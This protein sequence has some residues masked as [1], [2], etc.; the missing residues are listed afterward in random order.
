MQF[1]QIRLKDKDFKVMEVQQ[2]NLTEQYAKFDSKWDHEY[3]QL[4]DN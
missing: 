2:P 1:P 3:E 4:Q